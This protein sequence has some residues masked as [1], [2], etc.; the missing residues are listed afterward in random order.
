MLKIVASLAITLG[1]DV[2]KKDVS[3]SIEADK[4]ALD[5]LSRRTLCLSI[6]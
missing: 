1:I 5:K 4:G 2:F 3:T 6:A